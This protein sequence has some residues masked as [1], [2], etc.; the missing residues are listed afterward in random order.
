MLPDTTRVNHPPLDSARNLYAVMQAM[1]RIGS[2]RFSAIAA[3]VYAD[4]AMMILAPHDD[5]TARV[6]GRRH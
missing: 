4:R 1:P 3:A 5:E 2:D 6:A